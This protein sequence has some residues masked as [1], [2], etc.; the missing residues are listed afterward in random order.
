[1]VNV[2]DVSNTLEHE[3]LI[4]L[5]RRNTG[6]AAILLRDYLRVPIPDYVEAVAACEDA[7]EIAKDPK[8]KKAD[9]VII[10][11][12]G[13][14]TRRPIHAVII[15]VQRS[16]DRA[17]WYSWL[18]YIA[19]IRARHECNT[20][21]LVLAPDTAIARWCRTPIDTGHPGL[22]LIPVT[23][24]PRELLIK[25]A[26]YAEVPELAVIA[27]LG[28]AHELGGEELLESV[29]TALSGLDGST[30]KQYTDGLLDAL[31]GIAHDRWETMMA[32][33]RYEYKSDFAKQML[34]EGRAEG[35][36]KAILDFL[37]A[38]G[39]PVSD[40]ARDRVQQCTDVAQLDI[41]VTRAATCQAVADLF[42]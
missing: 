12:R 32:V 22:T 4:D 29:R 25:A 11:L 31:T 34:A 19:L 16:R 7:T 40:E 8:V 26:D 20:T 15:E 35:E 14:K 1:L 33:A 28:H 41:W 30:F 3:F 17:K 9:A 36:A 24:T 10:Y 39:I 37:A 18:V 2:S 42:E 27:A 21:L 5:F 23:T 13:R 38:R 6:L